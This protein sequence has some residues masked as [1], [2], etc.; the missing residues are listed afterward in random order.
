[1]IRNSPGAGNERFPTF[2]MLSSYV[3]VVLSFVPLALTQIART[4]WTVTADS[5]QPGNEVANTIDGNTGTFWHTEF[6]PVNTPLPHNI[7]IDMKKTYNVNALSYLPRQDGNS[8]GNIG[9]HQIVLSTDGATWTAPV[10]IGRYLGDVSLKTSSFVTK[11]ARYVRLIALTEAGNRGP[12]T[13]AAEINVFAA[14]SYTAPRINLGRWGPT[15]DLPIVPAAA[16]ILHDTGRLLTWSSFAASTF[17]GGAGGMTQTA[18]YDPARQA[19]SQRTITNTQHDMFCPGLSLDANGRPIV[20]GGNNAEKTSIYDPA[21]DAWTAAA[22]MQIPRGYQASTT[23]SDGRVFTIGG[24]WN[25]GQGGKNGEIYSPSAN[26]WTLLP[27]CPVT[28]IL[29]NDAQ[30]VYRQDNHAWL[31]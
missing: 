16:A 22:A 1:M 12:W 30:G 28:P 10:V 2:G 11:P 8:N 23:C 17:S 25:G 31:F 13:S 27:G 9:Q 5:F 3:A 19:V 18:T 6:N 21:A 4:G 15:V 20:T 24:S 29:T 26:T 14:S 7:T